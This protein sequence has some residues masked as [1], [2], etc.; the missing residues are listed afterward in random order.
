MSKTLEFIFDAGSPN[1]YLAYYALPPILQRT[2]ASL[3]LTPCLLGGI[4]KATGNQAPMLA[5]ANIK[6][7]LNYDLLEIRRFIAKHGLTKFHMNP[8]FPINTLLIMRAMVAA[9]P[10]QHDRFVP[11]VLTAM[12]ETG[13]PMG[14][15]EVVASVLR[16]AGLDADRILADA[17]TDPVKQE[18]AANTQH[19]VERGAFG[20]PTFFVGEEMFFGKERLDQVEEALGAG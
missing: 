8:N 3:A 15:P 1:A 13:K 6:G 12:W 2:G 10:A 19:A 18:L 17:Q 16:E 20:I 11:A 14:E 9:G 7:K 5:F 4:F